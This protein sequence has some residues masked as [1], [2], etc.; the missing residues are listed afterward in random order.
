MTSSGIDTQLGFS[1]EVT[2]GTRVVPATFI[3]YTGETVKLRRNRIGSKGM[4]AGRRTQGQWRPGKQWVDGGFSFELA[5]QSMGKILRWMMG[6]VSTTGAGPYTH[7]F[8]PGN[9]DDKFM[10]FQFARPDE[11]GVVRPFDY[12]GT[13]CT[14]W[15]IGLKVDELA[16]ASVSVFGMHEDTSQTLA[17]ASYPATWQPF[18]FLSGSLSIA[19]AAYEVEEITITGKNNLQTNRHVIK[20][21]TPERPRQSRESGYREYGGMLSGDFFNL[22]AYNRFVSGTEAALSLVLTDGAAAQLTIAGNVRFDGETPDVTGPAMLKQPLPFVF[23]SLTSD[24]AA[25]T[26]TLV[27]SDSTP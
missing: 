2:H 5:P 6:S 21:S 4:R 1:P 13:Q 22:T 20:S 24:S 18:S 27:N 3:P 23:T 9:L 14:D 7:T 11:A 12:T 10:T 8:T 16:Q 25:I 19:A 17:T 26:M 15:Q